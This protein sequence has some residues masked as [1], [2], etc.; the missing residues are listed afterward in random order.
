LFD[1]AS[2]QT[3]RSQPGIAGEDSILKE[4]IGQLQVDICGEV[5]QIELAGDPRAPKSQPMW[6]GV[7]HDPS[8]QDVPD[9]GRPAGPDITP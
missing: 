3:D 9:H 2:N 1:P 4:A 8:T 6:I 5:F 7:G